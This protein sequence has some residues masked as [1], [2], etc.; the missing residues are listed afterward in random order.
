MFFN[1]GRLQQ[2]VNKEKEEQQRVAREE[3]DKRNKE[4]QERLAREVKEKKFQEE[5]HKWLEHYRIRLA[6]CQ[7]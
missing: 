5:S 7:H 6:D 1:A 4:E 3:K 2:E